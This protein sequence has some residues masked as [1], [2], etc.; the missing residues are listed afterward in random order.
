M[1]KDAVDLDKVDAIR[2]S[3]PPRTLTPLSS[4][5]DYHLVYFKKGFGDMFWDAKKRKEFPKMKKLIRRVACS[6]ERGLEPRRLRR[7]YIKS[8]RTVHVAQYGHVVPTDD[9]V[10]LDYIEKLRNSFEGYL[11]RS[12]EGY[13]LDYYLFDEQELDLVESRRS[14]IVSSMTPHIWTYSKKQIIE[15]F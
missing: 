8:Q 3:L 4:L 15:G 6:V 2:I 5:H 10:P 7:F 12:P 13:P 14:G 11:I 1:E 9:Y